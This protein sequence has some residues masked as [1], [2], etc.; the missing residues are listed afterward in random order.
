MATK[1]KQNRHNGRNSAKSSRESMEEQFG[2]RTFS[3][4]YVITFENE[5]EKGKICPF[6]MERD[7]AQQVGGPGKGLRRVGLHQ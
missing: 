5:S 4:Y 7:I 3:R 6:Q 1:K 2:R